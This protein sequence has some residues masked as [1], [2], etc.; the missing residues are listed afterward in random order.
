MKLSIPD[1]V[2]LAHCECK[3]L[4]HITADMDM[5]IASCPECHKELLTHAR[6]FDLRKPLREYESGP[7]SSLTED[8]FLKA[9]GITLTE[10]A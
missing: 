10:S 3:N 7:F 1:A 4:V 2:A 5:Q 6:V 8:A 9:A